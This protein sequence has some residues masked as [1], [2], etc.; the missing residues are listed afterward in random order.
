M[1]DVQQFVTDAEKLIEV[2]SEDMAT[3][4]TGRAKPS[5][6]ENIQVEAYGTNMRLMELASITAPDTTMIVIAPWDKSLI[7]AIQ[8]GINISGLGFNP[9]VDNDQIRISI[10]PLTQER[11]E[12]MVRLVKQK[13]ESGKQMLRDV[14]LKFKKIIDDQKGKPGV[15][16]DDIEDDLE[17]LQKQMVLFTQKLEDLSAHKEQEVMKI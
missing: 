15:S 7:A 4:K 17:S 13:L 10:P 1:F 12:E 6:V 3:V 8:K 9:I 11:R 14:R 2:V 16:E 5:L